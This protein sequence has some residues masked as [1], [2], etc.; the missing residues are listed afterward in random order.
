MTSKHEP[1][2]RGI[3]NRFHDLSADV[4]EERL[5]RYIIHQVECG[6]H[7]DDIINDSYV[8]QHFDEVARTRILQH[9]EVIKGIEE[10]MRREFA[11]YGKP[12]GTRK[13]C[14]GDE[15][16]GGRDDDANLPDL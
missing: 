5:V 11:G 9:P 10:H 12:A 1:P 7:V 6:R 4:R 14:A 2:N 8:V 13:P 16:E 3:E 15:Q